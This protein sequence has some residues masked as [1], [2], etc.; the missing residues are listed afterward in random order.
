[1]QHDKSVKL[2]SVLPTNSD[3]AAA[4]AAA[5]GGAHVE[6]GANSAH[7]GG[8]AGPIREHGAPSAGRAAPY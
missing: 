6:R 4:S 7:V 2:P 8:A 3:A 1:L 5:V